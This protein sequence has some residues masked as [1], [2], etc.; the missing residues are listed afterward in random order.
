[1]SNKYRTHNVFPVG[2][3]FYTRGLNQFG[4]R[5]IRI[6]STWK[7]GQHRLLHNPSWSADYFLSLI[8]C[9]NEKVPFLLG[10]HLGISA[11]CVPEAAS[12]VDINATMQ[13][14]R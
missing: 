1:M 7:L 13:V 14:L 10:L 6:T 12:L 8:C 2:F 5:N 3:K 4:R 9:S 11:L